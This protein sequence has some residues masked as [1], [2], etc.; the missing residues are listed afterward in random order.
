[1]GPQTMRNE[2]RE[3]LSL[4]DVA[5]RLGI[6][7][8]HVQKVVSEGLFPYAQSSRNSARYLFADDSESIKTLRKAWK[9]ARTFRIPLAKAIHMIQSGAAT[10]N[11]IKES[12]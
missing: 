12:A 4:S 11:D 10:G 1:M 7:L 3:L 2:P 6:P 8:I 5:Y 9:L